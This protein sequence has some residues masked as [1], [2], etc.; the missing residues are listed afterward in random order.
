MNIL[1]L[2]IFFALV[3]WLMRLRNREAF[4]AFVL[5]RQELLDE[6]ASQIQT[7]NHRNE[8]RICRKA[9]SRGL[10]CDCSTIFRY[11]S[12]VDVERKY[13][14]SRV[15]FKTDPVFGYL[16][17]PGRLISTRIFL[18]VGLIQLTPKVVWKWRHPVVAAVAQ[19]RWEQRRMERNTAPALTASKLQGRLR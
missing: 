8:Q 2:L 1:L 4:E 17:H 6:L 13:K 11:T 12:I 5:E 19:A 16:F 14:D 10:D 15:S 7:R 18:K 3:A 9:Q